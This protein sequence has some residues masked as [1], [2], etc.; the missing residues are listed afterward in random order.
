MIL[1]DDEPIFGFKKEASLTD[2][3]LEIRRL[4]EKV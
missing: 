1:L 4:K 2:N 3:C